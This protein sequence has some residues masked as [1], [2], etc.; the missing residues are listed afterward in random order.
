MTPAMHLF[1]AFT[2]TLHSSSVTPSLWR[3]PGPSALA[4]PIASLTQ[5][6]MSS[7]IA[8]VI[9]ITPPLRH[10]RS[11]KVRVSRFHSAMAAF[12]AQ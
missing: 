11:R 8:G 3:C 4:M 10:S 12:A 1:G 6:L 2:D 7:L 9:M 5:S